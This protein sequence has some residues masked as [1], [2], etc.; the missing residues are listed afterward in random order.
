MKNILITGGAGYI[1]SSAVELLL[2]HGYRITIVDS[3]FRGF[4]SE[5]HKKTEFHHLDLRQEAALNDIFKNNKFDVVLHL[6]GFAYV[7][8]STEKPEMYLNNNVQSTSNI[9][10][11]CQKYGV[12][13]IIFSSSCTVYGNKNGFKNLSENSEISPINPYG[14]SKVICEEQIKKSGLDYIILRY[15]NV[16]GANPLKN[17]GLKTEF[18]SHLI[19][20]LSRAAVNN[21][22]VIVNGEGECVRDYIHV[23]DVTTIHVKALSY[24]QHNAGVKEII[25]CGYGLGCSVMEI[26]RHFEKINALKLKVNKGPFRAGDPHYLVCDNTKLKQ[27][28][29]WNSG[30]T[31]PLD[32]ICRSSFEWEKIYRS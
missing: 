30:F 24:L 12:T 25:N 32:A 14:E 22:E 29:D 8:E 19:H 7:K 31:N 2:E 10:K 1:G 5:F 27:M 3:L 17:L 18:T 26:I 13:K 6:A 23:D 9:I 28:L 15:F 20:A 11:A 16:A 4:I 21:H